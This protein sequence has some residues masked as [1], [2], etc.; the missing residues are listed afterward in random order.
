MSER[1][2]AFSAVWLVKRG[3][4]GEGKKKKKKAAVCEPVAELVVDNDE[5]RLNCRRLQN[6]LLPGRLS[7]SCK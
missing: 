2:Y 4:R 7:I 6:E 1:E 3:K 5:K